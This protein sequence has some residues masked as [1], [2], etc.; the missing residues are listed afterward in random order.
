MAGWVDT[1]I[2]ECEKRIE[3]LMRM[4][5]E[6]TNQLRLAQQQGRNAFAQYDPGSSGGTSNILM[7][8]PSGAIAGSGVGAPPGGPL[9]SQTVYK[10]VGGAFVSVSTSA[11]IYNP[12]G[13]GVVA[14]KNITVAPNPDGTYIVLAQSC[15]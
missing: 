3:Y 15:T 6:L 5:S 4:I 1:R 14:S 9:A 8:V 12:Y 7:C 2:T 11:S 10:I 13:A